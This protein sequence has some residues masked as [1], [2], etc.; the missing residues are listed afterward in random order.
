MAGAY[1]MKA[2]GALVATI[3]QGPAGIRFLC[4]IGST[5]VVHAYGIASTRFWKATCW[6]LVQLRGPRSWTT[7]DVAEAVHPL[8]TPFWSWS[9]SVM[10]HGGITYQTLMPWHD[11]LAAN[12]DWS[13]MSELDGIK[14]SSQT[15]IL[16]TPVKYVLSIYQLLWLHQEWHMFL[17]A[18]SLTATLQINYLVESSPIGGHHMKDKSF[19]ILDLYKAWMIQQW[20]A[21]F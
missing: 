4:F 12:I 13:T 21:L 10:F 7:W 11:V 17:R 19:A 6:K 16:H 14:P 18:E 1:V 9:T 3:E 5:L 15:K 8:S 20:W 2:G